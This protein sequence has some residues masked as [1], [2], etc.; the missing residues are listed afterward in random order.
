MAITKKDLAA[1]KKEVKKIEKMMASVVKAIEKG[2]SPKK[3]SSKRT[4]RK[5]AATAPVKT[6]STKT[7]TAR[8]TAAAAK[9]SGDSATDQVLEVIK[10]F[11]EGVDVPTIKKETGFDDKKVRNIVFRAS[12]Q[13]KI[14]KSG[15]GVYVSS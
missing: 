6:D 11:N 5:T 14:K 9:V 4:P 15:R 1:L 8:K 7:A 3:A 13:G 10:R 2:N 12:K